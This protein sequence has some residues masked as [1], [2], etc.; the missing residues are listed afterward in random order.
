MSNRLSGVTTNGPRLS[1]C[2]GREI[3]SGRQFCVQVAK[4]V[5]AHLR[6][7]VEISLGTKHC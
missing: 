6:R 2:L 5:P 3:R 4:G 7:L 1:H